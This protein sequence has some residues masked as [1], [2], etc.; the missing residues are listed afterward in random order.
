MRRRLFR[1]LFGV[2]VGTVAG[3]AAPARYPAVF[4][5]A[6]LL[7]LAGAVAG[8]EVADVWLPRDARSKGGY[9]LAGLGALAM[10]LIYGIAMQ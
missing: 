9:V 5:T 6:A 7:S 4:L 1:V 3:L 8:G 10:L 2:G